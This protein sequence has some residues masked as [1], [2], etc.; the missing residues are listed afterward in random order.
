MGFDDETEE[1]CDELSSLICDL[2]DRMDD[3]AERLERAI[4]RYQEGW[5]DDALDVIIGLQSFLKQSAE[6][7][8][9]LTDEK[10]VDLGDAEIEADP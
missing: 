7:I 6:Y 9:W 5:E 8:E 1:Y 2:S 10:W 3:A 4:Y